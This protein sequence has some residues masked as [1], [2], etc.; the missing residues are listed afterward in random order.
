MKRA[1]LPLSALAVLLSLVSA[2]QAALKKWSIEPSVHGA[3]YYIDK[4]AQLEHTTYGMGRL[5]LVIFPA[6]E[7]EATF[8]QVSTDSKEE[9]FS[10]ADWQSDFAGLRF[11]GTFRATEDEKVYPY[12]VAGV[13]KV[14]TTFDSGIAGQP[15]EEDSAVYDEVGFGAR[16]FLWKQLNIRPEFALHHYRTLGQTETNARY[17]VGISYFFLGSKK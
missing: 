16:I 17:S 12:I 11:L 8:E 7:V 4:D 14:K 6:F 2:P 13:G 1:A 9:R 3:Y 10:N 15:E 5:G